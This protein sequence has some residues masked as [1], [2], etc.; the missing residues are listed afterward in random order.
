[1]IKKNLIK[2]TTLFLI[3]S[4]CLAC[5]NSKKGHNE[6]TDTPT[7]GKI[8]IAVDESFRPIIDAELLVF[9]GIY[10]NAKIDPIYL[11]ENKLSEQMQKG[12]VRLIIS[13]KNLSKEEKQFYIN[14]KLVAKEVAIANDAIAIIINKQNRDSILSVDQIKQILTG[15]IASWKDI[16]SKS[17]N[18]KIEVVFDNKNSGT[19]RYAID[20]IC[21]GE[22]L[23]SHVSAMD[24][25]TDVIEYVNKHKNSIGFIGVSWVSDKDDSTQLSFLKKVQ[26]VSISKEAKATYDNSYQ[27]Y[28]AYIFKKWYPFTRMMYAISTDPKNGL[29][30][31]F[32]SFLGSDKGQRI[33]LK[34]GIVPA[35]APTRVVNVRD[36][37]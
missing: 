29:A 30:T 18:E 13:S 37:Y 22:K 20:S 32:V 12:T 36:N 1:M 4:F 25:N 3:S 23:T 19:V 2:Y 26:V 27:P 21:K 28:Q 10:G 15:K 11:P 16:N 24:I 17:S 7:S 5:N 31:G 35:V 34:S 9:E 33:I 6:A 8:K 14:K